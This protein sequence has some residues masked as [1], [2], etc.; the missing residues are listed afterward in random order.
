MV[1]KQLAR[2]KYTHLFYSVYQSIEDRTRPMVCPER[3]TVN[4]VTKDTIAGHRG[5][6]SLIGQPFT[7]RL[8]YI[9]FGTD[10]KQRSH[11]CMKNSL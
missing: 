1:D 7:I 9:A 4:H 2:L 8:A 5:W 10:I 3:K 6:I 11:G